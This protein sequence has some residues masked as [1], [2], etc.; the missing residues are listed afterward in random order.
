MAAAARNQ[1]IQ[2]AYNV[3]I[4]SKLETFKQVN[5]GLE[6]K[7]AKRISMAEVRKWFLE[8]DKG[9]LKIQ[10]GFNS[11]VPP[12]AKHELQVDGFEFKY[13]QRKRPGVKKQDLG[14]GK[15]KVYKMS[16]FD[17]R[18]LA[19]VNPHG[20]IAINP[21]TK[22]VAVEPMDGKIGTHD[23]VPALKKSSGYW[24][25]QRLFIPTRML[26]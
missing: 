1:K 5:E 26:P 6:P 21:F 13:K 15:G 11:F 7:D 20:L 8:N 25:N 22:K 3:R 19:Y 24:V 17:A 18:K 9:T 23:Y 4:G 10:T 14:D 16:R 12:S 2:E